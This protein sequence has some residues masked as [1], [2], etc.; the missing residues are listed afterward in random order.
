MKLIG[1]GLFTK[2]YLRED[3]KVELMSK[4]YIK[5]CMSFG[6]FPSNR[7]FPSIKSIDN[8]NYEMKYYPKVK[9]LK[10]SLKPIEYNKY[11][12]LRNLT[13]PFIVNKYEGYDNLYNAFSTIKG[14]ILREAMLEALSACTN[15]GSDISFE[16]S[17]RNVAVDKGNLV[18]LDCFF[19]QTQAD[20][21]RGN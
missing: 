1:K 6:W 9:S 4:D 3:G 5:E 16:I 19:I 7:L 10:K 8:G 12:E 17:L 2:A 15:Y 14:K 21:I 13:I 20:S 18:L 11:L